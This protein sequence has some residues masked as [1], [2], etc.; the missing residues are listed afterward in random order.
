MN[1]VKW[2]ELHNTITKAE[3][4]LLRHDYGRKCFS[5]DDVDI[6]KDD[7]DFEDEVVR[8]PSYL[9]DRLGTFKVPEGQSPMDSLPNEF[10]DSI[11]IAELVDGRKFLVNTEGFDYCRY[12]AKLEIYPRTRS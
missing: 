10:S 11:F 8:V 4:N 5:W 3:W 7:P 2:D 12:I 1:T 6:F 9:A